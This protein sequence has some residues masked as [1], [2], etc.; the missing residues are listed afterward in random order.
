MVFFEQENISFKKNRIIIIILVIII[1]LAGGFYFYKYYFK[2]KPNGSTITEAQLLTKLGHPEKQV[3][4]SGMITNIDDKGK[5]LALQAESVLNFTINLSDQFKGK[6]YNFVL[7]AKAQIIEVSINKNFNGK[8]DEKPLQSK[9]VSLS[10][11]KNGQRV[12]II[13]YKSEID[14]KTDN[15]SGLQIL[16]R[17]P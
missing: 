4:F 1:V 11:L 16:Y 7:D 9:I 8:K 3:Q 6:N 13:T 2:Q 5:S 15:F 14:S 10:D 12:T 17:V